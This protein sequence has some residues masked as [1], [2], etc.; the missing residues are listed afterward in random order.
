MWRELGFFF[1]FFFLFKFQSE[2]KLWPCTNE[3]FG[4]GLCAYYFLKH[5]VVSWNARWNS[6]PNMLDLMHIFIWE[7]E[8]S[9]PKKTWE[10]IGRM[11]C[12]SHLNWPVRFLHCFGAAAS[13]SFFAPLLTRTFFPVLIQLLIKLQHPCWHNLQQHCSVKIRSF[14]FFFQLWHKMRFGQVNIRAKFHS[15][16]VFI[17]QDIPLFIMQIGWWHHRAALSA[18]NRYFSSGGAAIM[19]LSPWWPSAESCVWSGRMFCTRAAMTGGRGL[20]LRVHIKTKPALEI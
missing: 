13:A 12:L 15:L 1:C 11:L 14:H 8:R 4:F 5:V 18:A 16:Y 19:E 3:P 20:G 6:F 7:K 2:K 9:L 10:T 17:W